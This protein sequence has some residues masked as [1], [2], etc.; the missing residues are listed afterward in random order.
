MAEKTGNVEGTEGKSVPGHRNGELTMD[1][2][3]ILGAAVLI[4][5]LAILTVIAIVKFLYCCV[6]H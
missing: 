6:K 2:I 5:A 4:E 1:M 3:S